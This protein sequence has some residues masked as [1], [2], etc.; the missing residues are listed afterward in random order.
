MLEQRQQRHRLEAAKR[1]FGGE[2]REHAGGVSASAIAAGIVDRHVPALERG[3]H[4]AG[5]RAVGRHQRR[6]LVLA[7][8]PPRARQSRWRAL[9][10]RRW[11]LRSR[12]WTQGLRRRLRRNR[13]S[14]QRACQCSVVEA[15]R[16]ASETTPRGRARRLASCVTASRAMPSAVSSA[17]M[18]NCG[19]PA[20]GAPSDFRRPRRR[21]SPATTARRD[22]C[23]AR[24]APPRRAAG[25]AMVASSFA[26]AGIEPVE[27][28]AITG[29]LLPARRCGLGLDQSV[30]ALGGVDR[31]RAR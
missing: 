19:W 6:G 29:A 27:P 13:R 28:A 5:E 25:C 12:R 1:G 21:R 7:F 10:P 17:C 20:A 4:A 9:P 2:P 22:P 30:A 16:S 8:R 26:V 18:E 11:R 24:A 15:G 23:R 3:Q 31:G 14:L